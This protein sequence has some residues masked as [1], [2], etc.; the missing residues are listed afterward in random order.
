MEDIPPGMPFGAYGAYEPN[1]MCIW[2]NEEKQSDIS[3]KRTGVLPH[4]FTHYVHSISTW[5]AI[6]ELL[7]LLGH[8]HPGIQRLEEIAEPIRLP[9]LTWVEDSACPQPIKDFV[10]IIR[11]VEPILENSYGWKLDNYVDN[12]IQP[13]SLYRRNGEHYLSVS[14]GVGV[15]IKRLALM[16]GAAVMK[17]CEAMGSPDDLIMKRNGRMWVYIAAFEACASASLELDPF[18][19]TQYVCDVSLCSQDMGQVFAKA[20][21]IVRQS[22]EL[23]E[24]KEKMENLYDSDCRAEMDK[25]LQQLELALS[26]IPEDH[27]TKELKSW[28]TVT[29]ENAISAVRLRQ[30]APLS[31]IE[32][33][34]FGEPLNVLAIKIGSP[35]I[36]T[37][38]MRL[39]SL[40]D[41]P[42]NSI[43]G[44]NSTRTISHLCNWVIEDGSR[45][46]ECPYSG[47]PGCPPERVSSFCKTDARKVLA[48][49]DNLPFCCLCFSARQLRLKNIV[50]ESL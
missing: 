45:P 18:E 46:I 35:V 33:Y 8:I 34:Y 41:G 22:K 29:L 48:L 32:P 28:A 24:F 13:V 4:E 1:G 37:N 14:A 12:A 49:S 44:R 5:Y 20:I 10:R 9:L 30:R 3:A 38:D 31:L 11:K 7:Y 43:P 16:E 27:K 2:L 36:I 19:V 21:E 17:K 15:P 23:S 50:V 39:T 26:L 25:R 42:W 40:S 47:C 6:E